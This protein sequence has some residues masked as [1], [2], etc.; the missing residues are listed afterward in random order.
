MSRSWSITRTMEM[1]SL[2]WHRLD[3]LLATPHAEQAWEDYWRLVARL[4][5]SYVIHT[6]GLGALYGAVAGMGTTSVQRL[7]QNDWWLLVPLLAAPLLFVPVWR[8]H[9]RTTVAPF[10]EQI[11]HLWPRWS[12]PVVYLAVVLLGFVIPSGLAWGI[13]GGLLV[14]APWWCSAVF[15]ARRPIPRFPERWR[16][17]TTVAS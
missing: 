6:A 5:R 12:S 1:V 13:V 2:S 11:W 17:F 10:M 14:A 16:Q 3:M 8:R 15:E 7:W 9:T 4:R